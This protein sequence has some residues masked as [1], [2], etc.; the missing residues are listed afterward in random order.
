MIGGITLA[1]VT[2]SICED[3][4]VSFDDGSWYESTDGVPATI[5]VLGSLY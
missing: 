4:D 3:S 5:F 1:T 2:T